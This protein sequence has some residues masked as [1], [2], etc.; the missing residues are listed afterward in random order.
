M[1]DEAP[2]IVVAVYLRGNVLDPECITQA[3]GIC[4]SHSQKKGDVHITATN[5]EVIAKIGMW[6]VISQS[7]ST[8]ADAH[9]D[10]ILK[11]FDGR[12][13]S[14]KDIPEVEEAYLDIFLAYASK[15]G[16]TEHDAEL[17]LTNIQLGQVNRLGLDL[18]ITI[19]VGPD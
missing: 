10:E 17:S 19:S 14:T 4:P 11:R 5:N 16:S 9:I 3:L 1:T 2:M 7:K 8:R 18:R 12:I 15:Q 6:G 13:T